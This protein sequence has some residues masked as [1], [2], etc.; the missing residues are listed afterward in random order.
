[1]ALGLG[2]LWS[3]PRGITVQQVCDPTL[4]LTMT[5]LSLTLTLTHLILTLRYVP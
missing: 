5:H 4:T 1:M 2:S 3:A